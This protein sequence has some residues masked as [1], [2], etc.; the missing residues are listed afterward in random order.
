VLIVANRTDTRYI[1]RERVRTTLWLETAKCPICR[2]PEAN[3]STGYV[4]VKETGEEVN[5]AFCSQACLEEGQRRGKES[6]KPLC[7]VGDYS[8]KD[9]FVGYPRRPK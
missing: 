4:I 5:A 1:E 9:G 8:A 6:D 3:F 2:N 7:Y